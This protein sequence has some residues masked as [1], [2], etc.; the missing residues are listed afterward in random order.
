VSYPEP[1]TLAGVGLAADAEYDGQV[2][3]GFVGALPPPGA[4]APDEKLR[5]DLFDT[6]DAAGAAGSSA[7]D[8]R[9]P[10]RNRLVAPAG[11]EAGHLFPDGAYSEKDAALKFPM[12][13]NFVEA[14]GAAPVFYAFY[15][16]CWAKPNWLPEASPR[17]HALVSLSTAMEPPY[18]PL[19][20]WQMNRFDLVSWSMPVDDIPS[21]PVGLYFVPARNNLSEGAPALTLHNYPATRGQGWPR[22][23]LLWGTPH[24][25]YMSDCLNRRGIETPGVSK[26]LGRLQGRRWTHLAM[27]AN[28]FGPDTPGSRLFLGRSL[29]S[30]DGGGWNKRFGTIRRAVA[31]YHRD[32]LSDPNHLRFGEVAASPNMNY[33]ADATFAQVRTGGRWLPNAV[34]FSTTQAVATTFVNLC[35]GYFTGTSGPAVLG[36][37]Y[38][39]TAAAYVSPPLPDAGRPVRATWTEIPCPLWFDG[40]PPS[41]QDGW[42]GDDLPGSADD[43]KPLNDRFGPGGLGPPDGKRDVRIRLEIWDDAAP[44]AP[45]VVY[46]DAGGANRVPAPLPGGTLSFRAMFVNDWDAATRLNHPLDV[47]PFLDDVTVT[48]QPGGGPLILSLD[49]ADGDE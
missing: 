9:G 17:P 49:G 7:G 43:F 16:A 8:L 48:T 46:E 38:K 22:R 2:G 47:T 1:Q 13:G 15:V 10:F 12:D 39:D 37:Y 36:R 29:A 23:S 3:L 40:V 27:V 18:V 33:V 11:Q 21:C 14:G 28:C 45:R 41:T 4:L 34:P 32:D 42:F 24:S 26:P 30:P 44:G 25:L 19:L 5:G 31:N 6:L 20:F 35:Q